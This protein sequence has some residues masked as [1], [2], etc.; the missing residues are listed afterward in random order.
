[1]SLKLRFLMV[2]VALMLGASLL[3]WFS[4]Q[5]MAERIVEQWGRRVA[6]VQVQYDSARLLQPLEREIAL[7]HQFANSQVLSRWAKAPDDPRL[8]AE[9]FS[10]MESFRRNFIDRNYFV[11]LRENGAYYHNNADDDFGE[12]P[13]RYHLRESR[14]ADAW[15]YQLI[16]EGRDFHLNVNPDVELG[17]TQL[18]IDVLM[19]D[20][21]DEILGVVGTGIELENILDQI[22]D[23]EQRGITTLF[24]DVHGAIQLYRDP[25]FIDFASF[26][27]PEGQKRTLDLLFD[28]PADGERMLERMHRLRDEPLGQPSVITDFVTIDGKRHLAG[29]AYLASIDWFEVTLL[30]LDEV[31]PVASFAP[32][33]GLLIAFLLVALLLF[34]W[35]LHRQLLSPMAA[36]K[37][38]M[39]ALREG[40]REVPLPRGN[41][42]MGQLIRHFGDMAD[43][44]TRHTEALESKVRERTE[45]LERLARIDVLTGLLNRRGMNLLLEEQTA[46]TARDGHAFGLIWLDLDHFK[47]INDRAGHA[48]GDQ[49]LCEVARLLEAGL[50]RYDHAARWGGDEFLVLLTPCESVDL[51]AIA[52]RLRREIAEQARYPGGRITVSV[53][54]CLTQPGETLESA[55]QRADEALYRAKEAGRNCLVVA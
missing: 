20:A 18:W 29:V 36:L 24:A 40:R 6:E 54:A 25:R 48:A 15:F 45:E 17:V 51:E 4:F 5:Y 35:A 2:A 55:L 47:E 41:G 19:R 37:Q 13:L 50:R 42:E 11:A 16:E 34:Y 9:A 52:S 30:D 22:I 43:E 14:P 26:I 27:K 1:M 28:L 7:A 21:D 3:A 38:A 46:R 49:A 53:G 23:I 8:Q 32:A 44:V 39:V 10:E 12:D 31:M 33:L